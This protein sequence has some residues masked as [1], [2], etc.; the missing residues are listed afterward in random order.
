MMIIHHNPFEVGVPYSQTNPSGTF[1]EGYYEQRWGSTVPN[2]YDI[3]FVVV[4]WD[5]KRMKNLAAK[6]SNHQR[7]LNL[8]NYN[9]S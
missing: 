4:G 5:P 6:A 8:D 1:N 2:W 3:G 9:P 7:M